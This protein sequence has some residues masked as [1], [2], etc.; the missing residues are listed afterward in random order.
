[1]KKVA[2]LLGL[3]LAACGDDNPSKTDAAMTGDTNPN[4]DGTTDGMIDG[5]P[6]GGTFT[7][8]V[9]D[10]VKNHTNGTDSPA[11]YSAFSALPDPDATNYTS[12][13]YSS[14]FM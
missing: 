5:G 8:Y 11:A 3:A 2:I 6:P 12:N 4:P 14:L 7:A 13:P 1:M 10:L 9:I